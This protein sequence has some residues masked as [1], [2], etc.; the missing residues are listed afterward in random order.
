MSETRS[1]PSRMSVDEIEAAIQGQT[2]PPHRPEGGNDVQPLTQLGL[3][4]VGA[5]AAPQNV[6]A[7]QGAGGTAYLTPGSQGVAADGTVL[8][9]GNAPDSSGGP[10]QRPTLSGVSSLTAGQINRPADGSAA[11][12][13]PGEVPGGPQPQLAPGGGTGS[14]LNPALKAALAPRPGP[15]GK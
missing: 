13:L 15:F 6:S 10:A 9:G 4:R 5:E 3:D 2:S 12:V 1:N 8:V 11:P 7:A 14:G